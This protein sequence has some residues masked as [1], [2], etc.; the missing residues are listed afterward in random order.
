MPRLLRVLTMDENL[1]AVHLL[2]RIP[3]AAKTSAR[4]PSAAPFPKQR[5]LFQYSNF[6]TIVKGLHRLVNNRI[7]NNHL[8]FLARSQI[9]VR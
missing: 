1:I 9:R 5:L 3:Y 7:Q 4:C 6:L 2:H 8:Y